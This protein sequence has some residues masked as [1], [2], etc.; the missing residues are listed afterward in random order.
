MRR[1]SVT[2]TV[3]LLRLATLMITVSLVTRSTMVATAVSPPLPMMRSPSLLFSQGEF[4]AVVVSG[5]GADHQLSQRFLDGC[6][7]EVQP[8]INGFLHS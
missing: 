6:V 1:A 2:I 3:W 7:T 4:T 5:S 8:V